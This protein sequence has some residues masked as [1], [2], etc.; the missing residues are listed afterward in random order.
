MK[1]NQIKYIIAAAAVV[2]FG[3]LW[4]FTGQKEDQ[5]SREETDIFSNETDFEEEEN[6]DLSK[7]KIYVHITGAVKN[8]ASTFL[9][10]SQE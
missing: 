4:I 10:K 3:V 9:R 7:G 5:G 2:L 6:V 1:E 8:R